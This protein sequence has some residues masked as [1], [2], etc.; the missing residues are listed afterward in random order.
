[1]ILG[2]PTHL[3]FYGV[4]LLC[5]LVAFVIVFVLWYRLVRRY[6]ALGARWEDNCGT[7]EYA[8]RFEAR[9]RKALHTG[10]RTTP[11]DAA[12]DERMSRALE[13]LAVS[14]EL[15]DLVN[16]GDPQLMPREYDPFAAGLDRIREGMRENGRKFVDGVDLGPST[17]PPERPPFWPT[18]DEPIVWAGCNRSNCAAV[19]DCN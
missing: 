12:I 7:L 13:T 3:F 2:I 5:S 15:D 17:P 6:A 8:E 10:P 18:A 1:M 16:G 4:A 11:Q 19:D 14:G 9:Y